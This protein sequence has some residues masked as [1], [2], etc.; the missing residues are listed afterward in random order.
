PVGRGPGT[1]EGSDEDAVDVVRAR[2]HERLA[3]EDRLGGLVAA[4]ADVAVEDDLVRAGG[5]AQLA[6][7]SHPGAADERAAG[8]QHGPQ[9]RGRRA[10]I[11]LRSGRALSSGGAGR[12]RRAPRALDLQA[13]DGA[14]G[15]AVGALGD[16]QRRGELLGE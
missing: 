5:R 12:P 13:L 9:A 2:L 10:L 15:I 7:R 3:L 14:L 6:D 4:R 16:A 8:V 11:A 1:G